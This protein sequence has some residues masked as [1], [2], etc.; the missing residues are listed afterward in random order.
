MT[1][2]SALDAS[3]AN[4]LK[5]KASKSSTRASILLPLRQSFFFSPISRSLL[6]SSNMFYHLCQCLRFFETE[7]A[8]SFSSLVLQVELTNLLVAVQETETKVVEI[9]ALNHLMSTQVLHQSQ[10]FEQVYDQV[11]FVTV[12][13]HFS[14]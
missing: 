6:V 1:K 5:T 11:R 9:S 12:I 3:K 7:A 13:I 8:C 14:F 10:H 4:Y 2:S